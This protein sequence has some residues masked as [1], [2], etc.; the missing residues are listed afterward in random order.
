MLARLL[1]HLVWADRRTAEALASLP[2]P[3]AELTGLHHH[4]LAAEATWL[5][6]IGGYPPPVAVWP[7]LDVTA[8]ERVTARNRTELL[9]LAD[10]VEDAAVAAR[11]VSYLNTRGDT[12]TNSVAEILHHVCLHGMY[13]RGQI[14]RGVRL[15]GGTPSATDFIVFAREGDPR[16][17]SS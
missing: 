5:A 13:H 3:D 7:A 6:R 14:A 2:A 16:E 4:L 11:R 15:A 12:F 8:V 10:T 17:E 1:R 9:V